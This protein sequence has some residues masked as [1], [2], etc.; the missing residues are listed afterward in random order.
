MFRQDNYRSLPDGIIGAQ[1][2]FSGWLGLLMLKIRLNGVEEERPLVVHPNGSAVLAYDPVRRVALMVAQTRSAILFIGARPAIEVIAGVAEEEDFAA[3]AR[4]EAKEEAG[5]RLTDLQRI[6]AVWMD[7]S[8]STE[9]VHLYLGRYGRADLIGEGG[10]LPEENE[11]I[12]V[13]ERPLWDVWDEVTSADFA[14]AKT[15]LLLQALRLRHPE[16]FARNA[17]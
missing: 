8:T 13:I 1:T 14:D 10:G 17:T 15:L 5:V 3:A 11:R 4:R 9:R 16:L 6:G 12:A 7:P 2:L